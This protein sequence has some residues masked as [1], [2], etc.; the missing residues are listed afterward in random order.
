MKVYKVIE[1]YQIFTINNDCE[2]TQRIIDMER[3]VAICKT[4]IAAQ[5]YID[6]TLE[7]L[8]STKKITDSEA[9]GNII[10]WWFEGEEETWFKQKFVIEEYELI[11]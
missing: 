2:R 9:R 11:H 7:T 10:E 6:D 5:E 8:R 3:V 1:R 4:E